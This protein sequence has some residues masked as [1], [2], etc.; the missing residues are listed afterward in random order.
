MFKMSYSSGKVDIADLTTTVESAPLL[1]NELKKPDI[2]LLIE[3]GLVTVAAISAILIFSEGFHFKGAWFVVP[4]ILIAAAIIPA[5][6][7]KRNLPEF[8]F[9]FGRIR[10]SLVI[11]GWTCV[12]VFP[13]FFAGLLLLKSFGLSLP[14][15]PTMPQGQNLISWILYQ[16][17][18]VAVAEEVFFR[19]YVQ[20]NMLRLVSAEEPRQY[21][22]QKWIVITLSAVCFATAHVIIGGH[23]IF[24]L[25]FVPGL[26]LGWLYI[27]SG[28]LLAPVLFHG[29]ANIC[30][31]LMAA[32]IA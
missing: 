30:Y 1:E 2:S 18:Y 28:S 22:M 29:L 7:Q 16:F 3:T 10:N 21:D 25:T 24:V 5:V 8:G 26:I 23:I 14:L 12:V 11:L 20:G 13:V 19:G 32:A 17:L 27:R 4:G 15:Q 9:S 31:F 6:I